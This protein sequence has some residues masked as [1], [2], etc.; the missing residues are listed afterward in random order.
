MKKTQKRG[1]QKNI[2]MTKQTKNENIKM[3]KQKNV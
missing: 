1:N 3:R 2:K